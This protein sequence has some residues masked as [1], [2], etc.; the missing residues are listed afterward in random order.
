VSKLQRGNRTLIKAMNRSLVLNTIRREGPLSR[1]RLTELSGL[2][3]GTV[4]QIT[5]D[6]ISKN[7]ILEVGE[8]EYTGGR[9]QVML[10]LNPNAGVVVGL[11]LMENRVVG[12]VTDLESR[13][14]YYSERDIDVQSE[15]RAISR[16]LVEIVEG[17]IASAR[18][19]RSRVIGVGIGLAGAVDAD[20]GIVHLSPFFGWRDVP[21]AQLIEDRLGLP[22]TIDNDVNTLTAAEQLFGPGQHQANFVV[23]TVGRGIG[24]GMVIEHEIYQGQKGGAGELGHITLEVGG[25]LCDCGK[26]GCLEAV[27]SDPAVIQ[28]VREHNQSVTPPTTLEDVVAL[29][30][31]GDAVAR[32]AL[33]RSGRYL[34]IGLATVVNMLCP[35][36]LIVSGEG[37]VAGDFRLTPMFEALREHT[38]N[39]LLD[40]VEI[41]VQRT[42]DR[43]WARG[44]ASV[45]IGKLFESPRLDAEALAA[46]D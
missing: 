46:A 22:V 40:G 33:N 42:D 15:P 41:V 28:Y 9:R 30:A 17:M 11:K 29:A 2:S 44:A 24:M 14:L 1:T 20:E 23:V 4:S 21:L 16:T 8:G 43:A 6:L 26:Q 45:V 39:G 3:V 31:R 35:S 38:F 5:N 12:A 27:A 18:V 13:V 32:E 37:V 10:R 25:P 7:W 19:R 34:G 36:L